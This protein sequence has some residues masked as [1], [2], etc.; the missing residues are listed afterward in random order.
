MEWIA[1]IPLLA[2]VA[3]LGFAIHTVAR[4]PEL[5]STEALIWA[6]AIV[7]SPIVAGP[8]WFLAGPHPFGIHIGPRPDQPTR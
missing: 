5:N 7:A 2:Y 4:S 6:I 3:V 1:V 8:V